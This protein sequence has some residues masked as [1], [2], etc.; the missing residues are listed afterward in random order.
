MELT[1]EELKAAIKALHSVPHWHYGPNIGKAIRAAFKAV[2][3]LRS[4]RIQPAQETA[5]ETERDNG[6]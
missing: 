4:E 5:L 1:D 6:S 2:G 3:E